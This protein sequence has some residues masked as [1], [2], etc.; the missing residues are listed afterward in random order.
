MMTCPECGAAAGDGARFCANCGSAIAA[1]CAACGNALTEGA[2]FCP[3]CGQPTSSPALPSP[4]PD[5]DE[6]LKRISVLFCDLVGFTEHT[7]R[8]DPEAVRER[9]TRY[10]A[11]VRADVERFGGRVEKLMGDGVFAVFGAPVVHEDDPERAVRAA[12]RIQESLAELNNADPTLALSVRTAVTTGEAILQLSDAPDREGIVGDVVNTASRLQG[13]APINGIVVDART[14]A[15]L[16]DIVDFEALDPVEVKGKVGAIPIWKAVSVRSRFGPALDAS[17]SAAFVGREHE[18]NLLIEAFHR[19]ETQPSAQ[20]VTIVGEPGVGKSRLTHELF[21]WI[22]DRPDLVWWRHGRCLPYGEGVTFWALGEIVKAH[23][24]ILEAEGPAKVEEKLAAAVT[25]ALDDPAEAEWVRSRLAPLVGLP[26]S[27]AERD[28][29]FRAWHRFLEALAMQH[30]LVLAIEDVHWADPALVSFLEHILDWS[31]DLPVLLVCT[32]RPEMYTQHPDWGAGRRD[33]V[34]LGLSALGPDETMELVRSLS[35]RSLMPAT[36]QQMLLERSGGN[37]LYVTEYVRLASEKGLLDRMGEAELPLPDTIHSLIAARLDLLDPKDK[38]LMQAAAVVGKVF[39]SGALAFLRGADVSDVRDGLRRMVQR[40][41]IRPVRRSSML[42][43][44]EYTFVHV[45]ARDVAY[46]QIPRRERGVLHHSAARWLEARA[47][48]RLIDVAEQL[49]H[50]YTKVAEA[51]RADDPDVKEPAYRFLMLAAKRAEGLDVGQALSYYSAALPF[52]STDQER[53]RA[54]FGIG[55]NTF[56]DVESAS[57][58]TDMAVDLFEAAGD[59]DGKVRALARRAGN[60]WYRGDGDLTTRTGEEILALCDR[61][62]PS[63]SVASAL[64]SVGT[65]HQLGGNEELALEIVERGIRVAQEV[66]DTLSYAKGLVTRGS[67]HVQLGSYEAEADV[68]EGIRIFLDMNDSQR[69]MSAYNNHA[70]FVTAVGDVRTG[71]DIIEEAIEYGKLR[72]LDA[73]VDWSKM[74]LCESLFPLGEWDLMQ[75]IVTQLIASDDA[76]GGSQVGMF[77]REWQGVLSYHRGQNSQALDVWNEIESSVHNLDDPQVRVPSLALGVNVCTA[78]GERSRARGLAEQFFRL[79]RA[80]PVFGAIHL[81]NAFHSILALGLQDEA[82]EAARTVRPGDAPFL[83]AQRRWMLASVRES[84][85][86]AS[87]IDAAGDVWE[88]AEPRGHRFWPAV[89]RIDAAR[90]S[91]LQGNDDD[92]PALLAHAKTSARAMGATRLLD[93]IAAL[94]RGELVAS[95]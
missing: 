10:H 18:L 69:V 64:I 27:G 25:A 55:D 94:E 72:G 26:S 13:I 34:T 76:R 7:E 40:E 5:S 92:V 81:P 16:R 68:E 78:A 50:H 80:H 43:Q 60:A 57:N 93:Q 49:A 11:A 39:W 84:D 1:S 30:P 8:S 75:E 89:A 32:A 12:L 46:S 67:T 88:A 47:E 62:P 15:A 61:L 90:A 71:R 48:D 74:T 91:L 73:H 53:A 45:L 20:L 66:G 21:T 44:E 42:G 33:A 24:G 79:L 87:V 28:E 70:T 31:H 19:A 83:Q 38:A 17:G 82:E 22:D 58:A 41:L 51:G 54:Y 95:G 4:A 9:L 36:A 23:A 2:K 65:F 85:D 35:H 59:D 86:L 63:E 77:A 52:A 56:D 6:E 29:L 14:H 3:S 37:P